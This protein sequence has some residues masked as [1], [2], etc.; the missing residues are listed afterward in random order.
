MML[1]SKETL[2]NAGER[3]CE[4]YPHGGGVPARP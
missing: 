1:A 3:S 4:K 2:E